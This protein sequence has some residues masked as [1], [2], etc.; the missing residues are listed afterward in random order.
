MNVLAAVLCAASLTGLPVSERLPLWA[1][2]EPTAEERAHTNRP[3]DAIGLYVPLSRGVLVARE[4]PALVHEA[5]HHLQREAGRPFDEAQCEAAQAR[6]D[7][8]PR[9]T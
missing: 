9:N 7:Q 4:W 5:C 8:C 2:R 3:N 1:P 6:A